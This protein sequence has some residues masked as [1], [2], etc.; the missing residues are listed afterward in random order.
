MNLE[1][2][3]LLRYCVCMIKIFDEIVRQGFLISAEGSHLDAL[4]LGQ[5][6]FI[7]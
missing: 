7:F 4:A 3:F 6:F 1:S 2:G 5:P